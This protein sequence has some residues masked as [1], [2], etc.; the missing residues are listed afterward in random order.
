MGTGELNA[1]E[2]GL[3]SGMV[4][5]LARMQTLPTKYMQRKIKSRVDRRKRTKHVIANQ[6]QKRMHKIGED[7]FTF[8]KM[9]VGYDR[10]T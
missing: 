4:G 7:R 5:H 8:L 3:S 6:K 10:L 1:T 9:Q 2:T